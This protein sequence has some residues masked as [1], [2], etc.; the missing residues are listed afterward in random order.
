M[1]APVLLGLSGIEKRF[2]G[3]TVLTGVTL[4]VVPG[5]ILGII[6]KNGAGK[7]TL[8]NLICGLLRPNGGTLA[9]QGEDLRSLPPHL[10]ARRGIARTFQIPQPLPQLTTL[11]NVLVGALGRDSKIA[12]ARTHAV[13]AAQQCGL[14]Y[15]LTAKAGALTLPELKRLELARALATGPR[16]LLLDEVM[17]GL[18]H[19]E[20]TE[21]MELIREIRRS[22]VT[23][24]LIE[25]VMHA[26][27]GLCD[28]VT[29]LDQGGILTTGDPRSV[30]EDQ[31][32]IDT[33]LG[34][35]HAA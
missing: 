28:R 21:T 27:M 12:T 7:T 4:D 6:G 15:R 34:S 14:T 13:Q 1:T 5:E 3:L 31:R 23:V 10:R 35:T 29:V 16:L 9:F 17:S 22:G 20:I 19:A 18:R 11:E 24:V 25:H 30:M 2:G 32:V 33:Y 26:V 8:F